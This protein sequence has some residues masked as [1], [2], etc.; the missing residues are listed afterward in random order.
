MN[1]EIHYSSIVLCGTFY[2]IIAYII[3]ISTKKDHL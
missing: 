1:E 3:I 2:I